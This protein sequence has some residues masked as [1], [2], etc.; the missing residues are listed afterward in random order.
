MRM[1]TI[2]LGSLVLSKLRGADVRSTSLV[3]LS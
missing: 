1:A 3:D 2:L